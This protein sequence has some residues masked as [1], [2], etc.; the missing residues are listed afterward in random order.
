[1]TSEQ[2]WGPATRAAR[3]TDRARRAARA[4]AYP[5]P[6]ADDVTGDLT[7][8]AAT[9]ALLT[10]ATRAQAAHVLHTA[11]QDLGGASVP[12]RLAEVHAEV[13]QVDVSL[14]VGEPLLVVVDPLSVAAMRLS[15]HLPLLVQDALT[16]AARCDV[17]DARADG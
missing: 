13:L 16:A 8:L 7:V 5:A 14:G 1:M 2:S 11:V 15:H 6:L 17:D 4:R 10:V 12:A 9:R 3:R